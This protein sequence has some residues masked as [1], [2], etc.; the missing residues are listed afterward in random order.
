MTSRFIEVNIFFTPLELS[1]QS[2][3]SGEHQLGGFYKQANT[4][5]CMEGDVY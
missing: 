4:V 2:S 5:G 3:K 1:W